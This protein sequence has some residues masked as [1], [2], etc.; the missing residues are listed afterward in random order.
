MRRVRAVG[1]GVVAVT[2]LVTGC[3]SALAGPGAVGSPSR[4]GSAS[5]V[6]GPSTVAA[7]PSG[8]EPGSTIRDYVRDLNAQ[9]VAAAESLLAPQ[10]V[11]ALLG[12]P[13]GWLTT[14]VTITD[15]SLGTPVARDGH[16]T[17]ADGYAQV[18][19]VPARLTLTRTT[20]GSA[21]EGHLTWGFLLARNSMVSRWTIV[22][23]GQA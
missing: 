5:Q 15:L 4:T 21:P 6:A 19:F 18:V 12:Q 8:T 20:T 7:D 3:G 9:D 16:G 22:D 11:R 2:L 14:S 10:H 23:D 17:P 13:G 1:L